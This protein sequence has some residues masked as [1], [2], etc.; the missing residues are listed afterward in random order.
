MLVIVFTQ[1]YSKVLA[2][3]HQINGFQGGP[4]TGSKIICSKILGFWH[5]IN[6]F[7]AVSKTGSKKF[8]LKS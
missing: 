2:P 5:Q 1:M 6:G 4:K 7:Q 3:W 8:F